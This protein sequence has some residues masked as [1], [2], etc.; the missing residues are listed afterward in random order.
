LP[1]AWIEALVKKRSTTKKG[2]PA[3]KKVARGAVARPPKRPKAPTRR[4]KATKK[5]PARPRRELSER[6]AFI[7]ESLEKNHLAP[8][9]Q[10]RYVKNLSERGRKAFEERDVQRKLEQDRLEQEREAHALK[11]KWEKA[12]QLLRYAIRSKSLLMEWEVIASTLGLPRREVFE[13]GL[14]LEGARPGGIKIMWENWELAEKLIREANQRGTLE[15]DFNKIA[16]A[17]GL[18]PREIYSLGVSPP[19]LGAAEP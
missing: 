3:K 10:K 1:G 14:Q 9:V 17:T 13:R 15:S 19:S 7:L 11:E 8:E 5:R 6:D 2:T 16:V 4:T 12:D 18:T